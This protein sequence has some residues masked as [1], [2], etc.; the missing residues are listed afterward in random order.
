MNTLPET[1]PDVSDLTEIQIKAL[2][3]AAKMYANYPS[4]FD[5]YHLTSRMGFGRN[6]LDAMVRRGVLD[7]SGVKE[8]SSGYGETYYLYPLT[9]RGRDIARWFFA[10]GHDH[11][12]TPEEFRE[13][14]VEKDA[15]EEAKREAKQQEHT[16]QAKK[17]GSYAEGIVT[18]DRTTSNNPNWAGYD[19]PKR[20]MEIAKVGK[21]FQ[22]PTITLT[23]AQLLTL[24]ENARKEQA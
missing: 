22:E 4:R 11:G 18:K 6:T 14:E 9:Q 16:E 23:F 13:R 12:L 10:N 21:G 3:H 7:C 2:D 15:Q 20:L 24:V 8:P 19:L 1:P 17:L 5:T